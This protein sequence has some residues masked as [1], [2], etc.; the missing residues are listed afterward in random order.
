MTKPLLFPLEVYN[1]PAIAG[2]NIYQAG[3]FRILIE[4]YWKSGRPL[5]ESDYALIRL[6]NADYRSYRKY[7]K[8]VKEAIIITLP[9]FADAREKRHKNR[10]SF[11][12]NAEKMRAKA[13]SKGKAKEKVFFDN[14]DNHVRI[15]PEISK[16]EWHEGKHDHVALHNAKRNAKESDTTFTDD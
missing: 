4:H 11:Q 1:H 12:Q 3:L 6:S 15:I 8:Q 9:L 7:C 14:K 13:K 10:V 5:P 2:L 16:K